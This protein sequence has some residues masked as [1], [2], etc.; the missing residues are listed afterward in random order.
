[1]NEMSIGG[2][3]LRKKYNPRRLRHFEVFERH[4]L[5]QRNAN[6]RC[7]DL[8]VETCQVTRLETT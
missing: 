3:E 7:S 4:N 2:R 5:A 8:S 6:H 1:M